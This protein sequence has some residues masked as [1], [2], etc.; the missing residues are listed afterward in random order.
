MIL[1]GLSNMAYPDCAK[2]HTRVVFCMDKFVAFYTKSVV[3]LLLFVVHVIK[4][5]FTVLLSAIQ[6]VYMRPCAPTRE[7]VSQGSH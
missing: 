2:L 1:S 3:H 4:N 5:L 7:A 6:F